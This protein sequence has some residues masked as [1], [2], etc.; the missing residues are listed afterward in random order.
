MA[1]SQEKNLSTN[2][3]YVKRKQTII[4]KNA[5]QQV[6]SSFSSTQWG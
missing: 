2:E 1:D 5:S 3:I 4:Q 6:G